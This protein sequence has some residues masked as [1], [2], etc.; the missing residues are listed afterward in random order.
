VTSALRTI[1]A[2]NAGRV[3]ALVGHVNSLTTG[4]AALC[5]IGPRVWGRLLPPA[6]PFLV[7]TDG[8][9]WSCTDWPA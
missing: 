8:Q 6:V 7:R 1:A 9:R 3:V 2:D 5:G 4:L